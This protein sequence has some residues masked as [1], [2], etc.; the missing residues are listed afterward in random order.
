MQCMSWYSGATYTTTEGV[1][2]ESSPGR[3]QTFC[4]S[5]AGGGPTL[6][7]DL[8]TDRL[9]GGGGAGPTQASDA[10]SPARLQRYNACIDDTP[11]SYTAAALSFLPLG[12]MKLTQG[13][14]QPGSSA[15]TTIDRRLPRTLFGLPFAN[16]KGGMT[17]RAVGS[18]GA[19][20]TA[21]RLG[22]VGA[23]VGTFATSYAATT[24]VR[25][26]IESR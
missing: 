19:V 18:S 26:A 4:F 24:I 25:C 15:F 6:G 21:G 3:W 20:K 11:G 9:G 13:F 7:F 2:W 17:V 14:R 5:D 8:G 12:N 10:R 1:T 23:V 22:T 16:Q